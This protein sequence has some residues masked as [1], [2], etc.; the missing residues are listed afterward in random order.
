MSDAKVY[1]YWFFFFSSVFFFFL[2]LSLH[3]KCEFNTDSEVF[4]QEKARHRQWCGGGRCLLMW[5]S[6]EKEMLLPPPLLLLLLLP[7]QSWEMPPKV[8]WVCPCAPHLQACLITASAMGG[9]GTL[10][11]P[12]TSTQFVLV[13]LKCALH[14][15][16]VVLATVSCALCFQ[17][18][19]KGKPLPS[20][21][22]HCALSLVCPILS[23]HSS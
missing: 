14:F 11:M 15:Q 3:P 13:A 23:D 12:D 19:A 4:D 2:S 18:R 22:K 16:A 1:E 17:N 5:P 9:G 8:C 10:D 6:F 21:S 7:H 20:T